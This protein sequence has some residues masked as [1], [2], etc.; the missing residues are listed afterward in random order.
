MLPYSQTQQAT[1]MKRIT[2]AKTLSMLCFILVLPGTIATHSISH[3]GLTHRVVDFTVINHSHH[4]FCVQG[5]SDSHPTCI[6]PTTH[7]Q[8]ISRHFAMVTGYFYTKSGLFHYWFA[9]QPD[10]KTMALVADNKEQVDLR[11]THTGKLVQ[12]GLN[13]LSGLDVQHY[14][15]WHGL[16]SLLS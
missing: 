2:L 11:V 3:H 16:Q 15:D 10:H 7:H 12:Q 6:A 9:N 8:H 1:K 14:V 5:N 13:P 4:T